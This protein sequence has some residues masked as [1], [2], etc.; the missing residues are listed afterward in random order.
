MEANATLSQSS[1]SVTITATPAGGTAFTSG[2][3]N[4]TASSTLRATIQPP[5]QA[6]KVGYTNLVFADDFN[7]MDTIATTQNANF[8]ANLKWFWNFAIP[9]AVPYSSIV[10]QP[11]MTAASI[12][13]G[14]TSG[15]PNASPNGGIVQMTTG[16]WQPGGNNGNIIT[17]PGYVYNDGRTPLAPLGQG[18][19]RFGYFEAV[20]SVLAEQSEWHQ[21]GCGMASVLGVE[22]AVAGQ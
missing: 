13:N 9:N 10:R 7:T 22:S 12:Q 1:Y 17:V 5:T 14:N 8:G 19:W 15:G 18:H 16:I 20:H 21:S 3:F 4:L 11:T 2:A 6:V